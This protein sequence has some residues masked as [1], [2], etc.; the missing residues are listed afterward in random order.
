MSESLQ[1]FLWIAGLGAA[2]AVL[3]KWVFLPMYRAARRITLFLEDWLGEPARPG[4]EGR[5][6]VMER[7][8]TVEHQTAR[9]EFHLGNGNPT[10]LRLI[11]ESTKKDVETLK[12]R[13]SN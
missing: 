2:L 11:V 4:F 5:K 9:A 8:A 6:G 10:P 1:V 3:A 7:L 13:P 12:R